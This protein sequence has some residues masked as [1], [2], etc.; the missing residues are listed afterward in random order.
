MG[1][2]LC[3]ARRGEMEGEGKDIS[4]GV[5]IKRVRLWAKGVWLA[6]LGKK[7]IASYINPWEESGV[8]GTEER[9]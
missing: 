6:I 1:Q 8:S 3:K 7:V 5:G 4:V 9:L 2:A